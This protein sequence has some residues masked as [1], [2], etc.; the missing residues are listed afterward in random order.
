MTIGSD[1]HRRRSARPAAIARHRRRRRHGV[2]AVQQ[3][4]GR[5][6]QTSVAKRQQERARRQRQRDIRRRVAS[7][8]RTACPSARR[9]RRRRGTAAPRRGPSAT[10]SDV[11][12]SAG[13][14]A[15]PTREAARGRRRPSQTRSGVSARQR[16]VVEPGRDFAREVGQPVADARPGLRRRGGRDERLP[17]I[18]SYASQHS[19]AVA[20]AREPA[21]PGRSAEVAAQRRQRRRSRR[22]QLDP[23]AAPQAIVVSPSTRTGA[24]TSS[25]RAGRN[26]VGTDPLGAFERRLRVGD[27]PC[28]RGRAPPRACAAPHD[29]RAGEAIVQRDDSRSSCARPRTG[30]RDRRAP[31]RRDE[32]GGDAPDEL[33]QDED[34]QLLQQL[35]SVLRRRARAQRRAANPGRDLMLVDHAQAEQGLADAGAPTALARRRS[36]AWR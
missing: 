17:S 27:G 21:Q 20:A 33:H 4:R 11:A 9:R 32:A 3:R 10:A 6:M 28:A 12:A 26:Q 34:R 2:D 18:A 23:D 14:S 1:A 7:L 15:T 31:P 19:G 25:C 35:A 5:S 22:Q 36:R 16:S 13:R 30:S 24:A 29:A 8:R